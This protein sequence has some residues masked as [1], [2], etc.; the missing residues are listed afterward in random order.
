MT[1]SSAP[2]KKLLR[3]VNRQTNGEWRMRVGMRMLISNFQRA[4]FVK[5]RSTHRHT[6]AQ[7]NRIG[8]ENNNK[9]KTK[10]EVEKTRK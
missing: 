4:A 7:T 5:L 10:W 8:V 6:D 3:L 1:L 9:R 2:Q